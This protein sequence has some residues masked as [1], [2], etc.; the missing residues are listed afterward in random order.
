MLTEDETAPIKVDNV[1]AM[2]IVNMLTIIRF[3]RICQFKVTISM[4]WS[5]LKMKIINGNLPNLIP[6]VFKDETERK[7][8]IIYKSSFGRNVK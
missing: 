5:P 2:T 7:C 1:K 3:G 8:G 4:F 6:F